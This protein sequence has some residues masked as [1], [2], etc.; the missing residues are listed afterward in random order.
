M[1]ARPSPFGVAPP[2]DAHGPF[3]TAKFDTPSLVEIY[4]TG[5]YLHN[6]SAATLREVVVERN[7]K[8]EHGTTTHLNEEQVADLVAYLMSL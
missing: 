3:R 6:G 8:D 7:R 1:R 4:R 2:S 5:P